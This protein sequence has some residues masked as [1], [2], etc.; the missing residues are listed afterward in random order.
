MKEEKI[1]YLKPS[2]RMVETSER[3]YGKNAEKRYTPLEVEKNIGGF[4]LQKYNLSK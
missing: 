1:K 4:T 3:L 2:K